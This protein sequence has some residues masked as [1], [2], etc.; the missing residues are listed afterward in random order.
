MTEDRSTNGILA[1]AAEGAHLRRRRMVTRLL[2]RVI[3]FV[4]AALLVTAVVVR[5]FHLPL[6]VFWMALAGAIAGTVAFAWIAGRVPALGDAAARQVDDDAG[7]GGELRSAHWFAS[8]PVSNAWTSFHLERATDRVSSVSWPAVYPPVKAARTWAG[9]A[10]LALS[11]IAVVLTSAWPAAKGMT[12]PGATTAKAGAAADAGIPTD[13][14]QQIDELIKAVQTGALP[15]D[16]ARA[17]V[18]ELRDKLANLDPKT[19]A[20]MAK[21]AAELAKKAG[22][23]DA[24]ADSLADRAAK[25]AAKPSLPQDMKWSMEDL[26]SKLKNA[27]RPKEKADGEE[28]EQQ[29]E[30]SKS[31]QKAE[32]GDVKA[33]DAGVQMSRSTAA[34]AQS[35]QMMASTMSPMGSER[36]QNADKKGQMGTALDLKAQLRKETIE[37]DEDTEGSNVLAEMRKKSEQQDSALGFSRIAPLA[38]YDK[39]HAAPPPPPSAAVRPLL[40]NYFIRK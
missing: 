10:L 6:S 21:A 24:K 32:A 12:A 14:Q 34:D 30:G 31:D 20:D 40:K 17:K 29:S 25:A 27:G 13:L 1:A 4:A 8:N 3:P 38:A 28:S 37:A 33:G 22:D 19:R 36:G 15:M 2:L 11:A 39:S 16:D 5:F 18:A 7:L 9:S 35:S 23:A 26:A